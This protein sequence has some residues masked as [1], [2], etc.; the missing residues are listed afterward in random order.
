MDEAFHCKN[1]AKYHQTKDSCPS[2]SEPLYTQFRSFKEGPGT[3]PLLQGTYDIPQSFPPDIK[4]FLSTC[5][6]PDPSLSTSL[7]RI[8]E[9]FKDS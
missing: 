1:Q 7:P 6:I 8:V 9:D 3:E 2:L 4:D 5:Q